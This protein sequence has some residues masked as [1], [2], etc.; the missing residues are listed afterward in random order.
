[1]KNTKQKLLIIT[2][3]TGIGKSSLGVSLAKKL[4]GEI[5]G[6]DSMQIYQGL[7][8]GTGKITQ[9]E[10]QGI[11]HHMIDILDLA[12]EYSAGKWVKD[13]RQV[14]REIAGRGRLPIIVGGTG[15]YIQSL[16]CGH[17]FSGVIK[18][19]GLRGELSKLSKEELY[20][21]LRAVDENACQKIFMNDTKRVIRALEI[22]YLTGKKK[23]ESVDKAVSEYD[24]ECR[25]LCMDRERLYA[26]IEARVDAMM[27]DGLL[28]EA[29][30][31]FDK[32]F[33]NIVDNDKGG[34]NAI[35]YKELFEYFKGIISF[36]RAIELIKQNS[37]RYAKRQITFFKNMSVDKVFIEI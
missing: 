1:M 6:A 16:L 19:E 21:R 26:R 10:M 27:K 31:L 33:S 35:G 12:D 15:L 5:I 3:P 14:I 30:G 7:D 20:E 13:A 17:E 36:D 25:V 29:R 8:I 22:F 2:G 24:Y 37:R 28:E 11:P 23:S 32:H 9:D 18:D 34:W 4:G